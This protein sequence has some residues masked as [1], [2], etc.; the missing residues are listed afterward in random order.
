MPITDKIETAV[1][2]ELDLSAGEPPERVRA[3]RR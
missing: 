2:T 3:S 1:H